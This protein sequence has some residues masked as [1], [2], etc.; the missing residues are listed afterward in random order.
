MQENMATKEG[1]ANLRSWILGGALA[2]I[3]IAA[4]IAAT[5]VKA[6]F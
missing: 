2:A 5:V 6:F 4:G 1:I 3:V